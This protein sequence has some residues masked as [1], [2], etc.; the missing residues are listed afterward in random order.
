MSSVSDNVIIPMQD[1]IN[2]GDEFSVNIPKNTLNNWIF[3][4]LESDLD[5]TLSKNISFITRLYGRA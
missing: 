2:L 4:L 3:R 1:Y 5:A